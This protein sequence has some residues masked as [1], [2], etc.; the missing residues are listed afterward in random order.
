MG[1]DRR[2]RDE[3][4]SKLQELFESTEAYYEEICNVLSKSLVSSHTCT[5]RCDS[6]ESDR[7]DGSIRSSS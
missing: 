7:I 2:E 6:E 3:F 1:V 5:R 4:K